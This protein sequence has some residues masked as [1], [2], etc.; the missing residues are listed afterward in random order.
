M[1]VD[2]TLIILPIRF[3]TVTEGV[4]ERSEQYNILFASQTPK[5]EEISAKNEPNFVNLGKISEQEKIEIIQT[6][7]KVCF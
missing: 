7:L 1:Y 2:V 5:F 4:S 6:G 3:A